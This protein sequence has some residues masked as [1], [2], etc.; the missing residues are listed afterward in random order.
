[1]PRVKSALS[2]Q[3]PTPDVLTERQ[4]SYVEARSFGMTKKDAAAAAGYADVNFEGNKLEKLPKITQALVAERAK[5]AFNLGINKEQVL[6]G[7]LDAIDDAKL[8]S[9]PATQIMGWK[10]VAKMLGFYAPE[11]KKIELTGPAARVL[12]RMQQLS[13]EELLRIAESDVVDVEAREVDP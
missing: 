11:V 4:A 9:D 13:D 8:L 7:I 3:S 1:M 10:E 12:D 6:Q 5:T 2:P